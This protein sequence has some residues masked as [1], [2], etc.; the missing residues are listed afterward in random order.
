[1]RFNNLHAESQSRDDKS[2]SPFQTGLL[3]APL[4]VFW[5][6]CTGPTQS[7]AHKDNGLEAEAANPSIP[8]LN[9]GGLGRNRTTDTRI[10]NPTVNSLNGIELGA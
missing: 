6:D 9:F 4:P 7:T 8:L 2:A 1:M 10:F 5:R 3:K